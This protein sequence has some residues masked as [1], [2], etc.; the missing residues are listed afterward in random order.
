MSSYQGNT[1]HIDR[2]EIKRSVMPQHGQWVYDLRRAQNIVYDTNSSVSKEGWQEL[3]QLLLKASVKSSMED[4]DHMTQATRAIFK[5][6]DKREQNGSLDIR[7]YFLMSN[8]RCHGDLNSLAKWQ[9]DLITELTQ[10]K[11]T[12]RIC[13]FNQYGVDNIWVIIEEP[14]TENIFDYS[15]IYFKCLSVNEEVISDFL[16]FGEGEVDEISLPSNKI[17]ILTEE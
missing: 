15:N 2:T 4:C 16:V 9:L 5:W 10:K 17:I 12:L 1:V 8:M 6:N 13:I 14:S 11:G 7:R 3:S